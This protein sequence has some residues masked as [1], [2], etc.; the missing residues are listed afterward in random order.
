M[1]DQA[2]PNT[3]ERSIGSQNERTERNLSWSNKSGDNG[4]N[5]I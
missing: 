1:E 4:D 3:N 2:T 5:T